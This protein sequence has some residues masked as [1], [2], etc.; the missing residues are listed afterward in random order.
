MRTFMSGILTLFLLGA[1]SVSFAAE[2]KS[3]SSK[4]H[5]KSTHQ[6][7][8]SSS[9]TRGSTGNHTRSSSAKSNIPT[10]SN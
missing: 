1:T 9:H 7:K 4:P 3:E 10:N 5:S 6:R 8:A 2:K